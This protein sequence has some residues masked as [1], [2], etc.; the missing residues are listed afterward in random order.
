MQARRSNYETEQ[1]LYT[2]LLA[3]R[4]RRQKRA[5]R[6]RTA[7]RITGAMNFFCSKISWGFGGKAPNDRDARQ[8]GAIKQS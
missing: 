6:L 2:R 4:R 3:S 8:R 1:A 5:K 7:R